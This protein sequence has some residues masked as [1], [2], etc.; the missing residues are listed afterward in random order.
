MR[1]L[2]TALQSLYNFTHLFLLATQ[3]LELTTFL[4][5][6]IILLLMANHRL[7]QNIHLR[8]QLFTMESESPFDFGF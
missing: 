5:D 7:S 2:A 4:F 3:F 1:L 8:D 6:R